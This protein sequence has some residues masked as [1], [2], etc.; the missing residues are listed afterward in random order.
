[1]TWLVETLGPVIF[2]TKPS[3]LLSFSKLNFESQSKIEKIEKHMG[4]CS[5]IKYKVFEFKKNSI[6]VL[7]Y[8]PST[9]D[10]N[11]RDFKNKKCLQNMGY[12]EPYALEV[13]I[14][15]LILKMQGG[16]IPHEIGIFLGYPLKDI[17]GFIGHPSLKLTKVNGWRVYGD[18][19]LSDKIHKEFSEARKQI[20]ELLQFNKPESILLSL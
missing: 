16:E 15:L 6:K 13:Y 12:P 18:P 2:G 17:I 20:K 11:L 4:K 3:E 1:M 7:F 19:R 10:K 9:M 5:R 8:N 14:E